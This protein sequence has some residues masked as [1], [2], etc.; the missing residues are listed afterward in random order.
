[1]EYNITTRT[2]LTS[3]QELRGY[4]GQFGSWRTN[5]ILRIKLGD[6]NTYFA[7]YIQDNTDTKS[8]L[9]RRE[10]WSLVC[11]KRTATFRCKKGFW[12]DILV[13]DME[14]RGMPPNRWHRL[15]CFCNSGLV[16]L[17]AW[18]LYAMCWVP[19]MF[20]S[21]GCSDSQDIVRLWFIAFVFCEFTCT[22]SSSESQLCSLVQSLWVLQAGPIVF[23]TWLFSF[24]L[25]SVFFFFHFDR[26][27]ERES[28]GP[29]YFLFCLEVLF[30]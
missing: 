22:N 11:S 29:W 30:S 4:I 7:N 3:K 10:S 2:S 28:C 6:Q 25:F 17:W 26:E 8:S 19:P 14:E 18:L 27:R 21:L 13:V 9:C 15:V 20:V 24:L 1:M 16:C 5:L 12:E 23:L